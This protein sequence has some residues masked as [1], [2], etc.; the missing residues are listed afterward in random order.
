MYCGFMG[1]A[2]PH[3]TKDCQ[4]KDFSYETVINNQ[5]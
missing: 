1:N 4:F 2:Y 3:F 5:I